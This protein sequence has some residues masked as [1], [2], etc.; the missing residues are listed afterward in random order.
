MGGEVLYLDSSALVKLV[1]PEAE[2][3]ALLA[4]LSSWRSCVSSELARVEV[5]RAVRRATS[6]PAAERRAEEVL[7]GLHLL[8]IDG[9]VLGAAARLEP[10]IVRSLD[11]IHLAS[12]LSLGADLGAIAVY[13]SNLA[14]AAAGH[15]L[16]VLAPSA[17]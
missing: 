11:A 5:T 3:E 6:H 12:A 4:S 2:T 14:T 15:G 1:L 9:D 10:R 7:A 16:R 8:R 13:D 17:A